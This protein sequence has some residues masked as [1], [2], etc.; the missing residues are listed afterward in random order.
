MADLP[1]LFKKYT[2]RN[3]DTGADVADCFVLRPTR[4]P[5]ARAAAVAY[6]QAVQADNP[7]LAAD[8]YTWLGT[9]FGNLARGSAEFP[10]PADVATLRKQYELEVGV[11][12]WQVPLVPPGGAR[13]TECRSAKCRAPVF[14]AHL[15]KKDGTIGAAT[16][17]NWPPVQ[18]YGHLAVVG[19]DQFG[20]YTIDPATWGVDRAPYVHDDGKPLVRQTTEVERVAI[21]AANGVLYTGHFGTCPD[22]EAFRGQ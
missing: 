12:G 3:N 15:L 19:Q 18:G 17:V 16:P 20:N 7:E 6:A 5:A 10:M 1:G 13:L 21:N 9:I 4:D 8:L 22:A 2:V 11:P 14:Y